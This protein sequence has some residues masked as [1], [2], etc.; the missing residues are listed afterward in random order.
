MFGDASRNDV[1]G[2]GCAA[3][4]AGVASLNAGWA[5]NDSA[6][7]SCGTG[8]RG[9]AGFGTFR[10]VFRVGRAGAEGCSFTACGTDL[11]TMVTGALGAGF[12]MR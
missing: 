2:I 8:A 3:T 9:G 10:A 5:E 6:L 4:G 7:P 1:W 11:A 12:S